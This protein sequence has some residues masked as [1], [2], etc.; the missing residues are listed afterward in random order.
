[1]GEGVEI[2]RDLLPEGDWP[3]TLVDEVGVSQLMFDSLT[4][5][6]HDGLTMGAYVVGIKGGARSLFMVQ[7]MLNR[8]DPG[9]DAVEKLLIAV[10]MS[11]ADEVVVVSE[12]WMVD[13]RR[14]EGGV[15]A[16]YHWRDAHGGTLE[17]HPAASERITVGFHNPDGEWFAAAEILRDRCVARLGPW[18]AQ[19]Q[20]FS[21]GQGRFQNLF[22][23]A[24]SFT[25]E[26]N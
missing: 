9:K 6:L 1:M 10:I 5:K 26:K 23:K 21:P 15:D 7:E 25:G 8:R 19:V 3:E 11:G 16:V 4:A 24:Q 12:S 14:V 13:A 22:M 17:G 18:A 20:K 2:R